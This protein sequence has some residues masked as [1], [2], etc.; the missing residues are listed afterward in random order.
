MTIDDGTSESNALGAFLRAQRSRVTPGEAGLHSVGSRRVKGLRREEVAVL[1]GVSADYYARLEQGRERTPS[2]QLMEAISR[3]LLLSPDARDHAFRLARLAPVTRISDERPSSHLRQ[4]LDSF[5]SAAAYVVNPAFR[6]I[7]AN[8]IATGLIAPA[9]HDSQMLQ[10]MFLDP[11]ARIY[12]RDWDEVSRTAV[13]AIRLAAGFSPPHP[14]VAAQVRRLYVR[15]PEFASLWDD[16]EVQGLTI[17]HKRI[18]HPEVGDL[19]LSYQTFDVREAPGLQ[20]T[21][22][23]AQPGSSSADALSLL[24]A[25]TA[26]LRTTTGGR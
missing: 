22:A 23:T 14:E 16:R 1:A 4:V 8:D 12:F 24:G 26:T 17:V 7:A 15:S 13:S 18:R 25:L 6:V 5:P 19:E 11:S 3:A 9:H 10:Y 21:V 20:L 2:P